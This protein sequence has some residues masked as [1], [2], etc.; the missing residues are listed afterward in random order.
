MRGFNIF[1]TMAKP[2]GWLIALLQI[3][4]WSSFL[5]LPYYMV[6]QRLIEALQNPAAIGPLPDNWAVS[7]LLSTLPFNISLIL[8]FYLHHYFLFDRLVLRKKQPLYFFIIVVLF[9]TCLIIGYYS[10]YLFF[11]F[12]PEFQRDLSIRDFVRYFTWFMLVLLASLGL[13]LLSQWNRAEKRAAEIEN[14]RLRT[15]LSMLLA[16]IN[17]HFLFNSLN[18][19]YSL[20]IKK[21]DAAPE[22]VLKLSHLF[23]YVIED[24]SNETVN[25]EQEVNYL[26]NYIDMQKL[27][28]TPNTPIN[29]D[30]T[31]NPA[32][33]NVAPLLYL[34][35]VEN[36]FKYGISNSEP[37]A[38]NIKLDCSPSKVEFNISNRKFETTGKR[39]TG[40]GLNN[41]RRRLQLLYPDNHTL[42]I[43]ESIEVYSVTLTINLV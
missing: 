8:M 20:S 34:P 30:I 6:P 33:V 21:S 36:A 15:E 11:N 14:E 42:E 39:S 26:H 28:V 38:I 37:S 29:F 23:R 19:V 2:R 43:N 31:G 7:T 4:I 16:Q 12:L 18:T 40:I 1:G 3:V 10:K 35:L 41:V 27:R 5:I 17:P 22:A 9:A 24:G 25:L 32:T 13:K